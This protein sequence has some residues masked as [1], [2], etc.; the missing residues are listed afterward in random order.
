M[1][2]KAR[3]QTHACLALES[4]LNQDAPQSP[5][6]KWLPPGLPSFSTL[7]PFPNKAPF[8]LQCSQL[9]SPL[10]APIPTV[11]SSLRGM[12]TRIL[13][14]WD[15]FLSPLSQDPEALHRLFQPERGRRVS[16]RA[17]GWVGGGSVIGPHCLC[18]GSSAEKRT[19]EDAA[20]VPRL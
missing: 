5:A 3:V 13:L 8:R 16:C 9:G 15:L 7:H 12:L 2:G 10:T 19:E 6:W 1:I 4:P 11:P 14:P 20:L 17:W 18:P